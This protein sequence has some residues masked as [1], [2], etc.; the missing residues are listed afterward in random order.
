[1]DE[2]RRGLC[3]YLRQQEELGTPDYVLSAPLSTMLA[4]EPGEKKTG[5]PVQRTVVSSSPVVNLKRP[6]G[7]VPAAHLHPPSAPTPAASGP[8][9]V[10]DALV[11]LFKDNKSC[12]ACG[13]ARTRKNFVFGSGNAHAGLMVIGEAPGADED[14]QGLP[15]VGRAGELLTKMLA[16]VHLDRKRDVFIANVLKCRPP[17]NRNPEATE[18]MACKH[19]LLSQID[20]IKPKIILLLG[21]IAAHA[22][23][24]TKAS[25]AALRLEPHTVSGVPAFVTYHPASLLRNEEYKRPAWEDMLKLKQALVAAGDHANQTI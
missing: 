17:E 9:P 14:E 20:I 8:D 6:S 25:I 16:A 13:L 4:M 5:F 12:A 7:L 24:D 22:L 3:A 23:L 21:R 10:R 15:F 19:I 11:N 18:I 2:I 1:M